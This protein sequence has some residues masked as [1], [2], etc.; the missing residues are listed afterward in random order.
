MTNEFMKYILLCC[1]LIIGSNKLLLAKGLIINLQYKEH[2]VSNLSIFKTTPLNIDIET[3]IIDN[4]K[5]IEEHCINIFE[6]IK[7]KYHEATDNPPIFIFTDRESS[8]VGL[9]LLSIDNSISGMCSISGAFNDGDNFLYSEISYKKNQE[10]LNS[11]SLDRSKEQYLEKA[12]KL[13]LDKKNGKRIKIRKNTDK[14]ISDLYL[15]LESSYGQSLLNFSLEEHLSKI[16]S[17]IYPFFGPKEDQKMVEDV[18]Y[19]NLSYIGNK[20]NV[21]YTYPSVWDENNPLLKE[22]VFDLLKK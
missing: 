11:L 12:L 10:L 5:S 3:Y 17:G 7:K 13:I 8:F 14:N 20:Y 4:N 15:F 1:F 9:K 22:I 2:K 16:E 6:I 19:M 18:D 21:K